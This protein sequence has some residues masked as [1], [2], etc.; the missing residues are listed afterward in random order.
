[1]RKSEWAITISLIIIISM[2]LIVLIID[3]ASPQMALHRWRWLSDLAIWI[4][5]L[6]FAA[7]GL[8]RFF[9]IAPW[10][11]VK[12][13]FVFAFCYRK[14]DVI[15]P[16]V[17]TG[18]SLISF[19]LAVFCLFSW[20]LMSLPLTIFAI[21]FLMLLPP[22]LLKQMGRS[23]G[24]IPRK[25]RVSKELYELLRFFIFILANFI[26]LDLF[27]TFSAFMYGVYLAWTRLLM[28]SHLID[29]LNTIHAN[30]G[31]I[32]TYGTYA[33]GVIVVISFTYRLIDLYRLKRILLKI[34]ALK[35]YLIIEDRMESVLKS[36]GLAAV[37]VC[38]PPRVLP[39][40]LG[41]INWRG[42]SYLILPKMHIFTE[43]ELRAV[44]CHESVHTA[45]DTEVRF[46]E[47]ERRERVRASLL[48]PLVF[49]V[50][51][52]FMFLAGIVVLSCFTLVFTPHMLPYV[53]Y[54]FTLIVIVVLRMLVKALMTSGLILGLLPVTYLTFVMMSVPFLE[55]LSVKFRE[56]RADFLA[57]LKSKDPNALESALSKLRGIK[58]RR[59]GFLSTL[60][61][62]LKFFIMFPF[63]GDTSDPF[64]A[65]YFAAPEPEAKERAE[66]ERIGLKKILSFGLKDVIWISK[67][68]HPSI[69][70]RLYIIRMARALLEDGLPVEF[71]RELTERDYYDLAG[72]IETFD[73]IKCLMGGI[74]T[75]CKAKGRFTLKELEER[76]AEE[77]HELSYEELFSALAFL[78]LRG[79][80]EIRLPEPV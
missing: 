11:K 51:V 71:R 8:Y 64:L 44:L 43:R 80:A 36:T 14:R 15:L 13:E 78:E 48:G 23:L 5:L 38:M 52:P 20:R 19:L 39:W 65:F 58:E 27:Y 35:R 66:K 79:I 21:L 29:F 53:V 69:R 30:I 46:F 68:V 70:E 9:A 7:Y 37:N 77:G 42:G 4:W 34:T 59:K 74:Y 75:L 22:I 17:I 25:Y 57:T 3:V 24:I 73:R 33:V 54:N 2:N 60:I 6:A 26:F 10:K 31:V 63:K 72:S 18:I 12:L 61:S 1:M 49:S 40:K 76:M 50:P 16:A 67:N 56:A 28:H 55:V 62:S 41:V 47:L 45:L 32:I